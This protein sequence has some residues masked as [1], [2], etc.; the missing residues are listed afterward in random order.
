MGVDQATGLSALC[1][2]Q[3]TNQALD[4]LFL[5]FPFKLRHFHFQIEEDILNEAMDAT[6]AKYSLHIGAGSVVDT[7]VGEPLTLEQV[8]ELDAPNDMTNIELVNDEPAENWTEA[9]TDQSMGEWMNERTPLSLS[10]LTPE[11]TDE[12]CGKV[13]RFLDDVDTLTLKGTAAVDLVR[14]GLTGP[15]GKT[16]T[17]I[18]QLKIV[19]AIAR[20]DARNVPNLR[21][22]HCSHFNL[23]MFLDSRDIE[24]LVVYDMY[25]DAAERAHLGPE[26]TLATSLIKVVDSNR[27][28]TSVAVMF[29]HEIPYA[30]VLYS[31]EVIAEL[32]IDLYRNFDRIA[33]AQ[34]KP[35][36]DSLRHMFAYNQQERSLQV[37][38][39]SF[40]KICQLTFCKCQNYEHLQINAMYKDE[41]YGTISG[42]LEARK[43]AGNSVKSLSISILS[44]VRIDAPFDRIPDL[45][46]SIM[47]FADKFIGHV[48]Q[49][50]ILDKMEKK[51]TTRRFNVSSMK[52]KGYL[53]QGIQQLHIAFETED[54]D[55]IQQFMREII[56]MHALKELHI[57]SDKAMMLELP[58]T[59]DDIPVF[60][61]LRV[62]G[63]NIRAV[64][65]LYTNSAILMT[66]PKLMTII[67]NDDDDDTY[68]TGMDLILT[69]LQTLGNNQAWPWTFRQNHLFSRVEGKRVVRDERSL[70]EAGAFGENGDV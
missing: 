64:D 57:R 16:Q 46:V 62:L 20:L 10:P 47:T 5:D 17:N 42:I 25:K 12:F 67:V 60:G 66:L 40:L 3:T 31:A 30:D 69:Q 63:L 35:S 68:V 32:L 44:G 28:L 58:P 2:S 38:K 21:H 22:L 59:Y 9:W 65:I 7:T 19:N 48:A 13:N 23:R 36:S 37:E 61:E 56:Q 49:Y 34:T 70:F 18:K 8:L 54:N 24:K 14:I 4:S 11:L 51:D 43:L 45:T 6:P 29:H 52:L 41:D 26:A 1:A 39:A 55:V 50:H 15:V 33:L 53:N 27:S